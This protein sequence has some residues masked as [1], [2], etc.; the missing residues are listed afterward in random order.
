MAARAAHRKGRMR[1]RGAN[2][3]GAH[4]RQSGRAHNQDAVRGSQRRQICSR[5][6]PV[7]TPSAPGHS[8]DTGAVS[9]RDTA[10]GKGEAVHI[11]GSGVGSIQ[12]ACGG[13]TAHRKIR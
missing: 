8:R 13:A 12:S 4:A 10:A 1:R 11:G 9:K 3:N 6:S 5:V 7:G 2:A